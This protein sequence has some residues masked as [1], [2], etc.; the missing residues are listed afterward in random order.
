[1]QSIEAHQESSQQRRRRHTT[2]AQMVPQNSVAAAPLCG[3]Y[4]DTHRP[5]EQG[6][7]HALRRVWKLRRKP[8]RLF[9]LIP[10]ALIVSMSMPAF[11]Q[12]WMRFV[13]RDDGFSANY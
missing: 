11:A 1:M 2:N 9:L 8:M 4:L 12:D 5:R 3:Q 13:S 7:G 10:A 6:G